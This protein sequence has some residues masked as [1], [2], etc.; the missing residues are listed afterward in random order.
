MGQETEEKSSS[1]WNW[2]T[3]GVRNGALKSWWKKRVNIH[4]RNALNFVCIIDGGQFVGCSAMIWLAGPEI[5]LT[6]TLLSISVDIVT[7]FLFF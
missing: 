5:I 6:K 1:N 4:L 3:C 2:D 7:N